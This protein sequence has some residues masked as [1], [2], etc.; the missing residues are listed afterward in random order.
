MREDREYYD[1]QLSKSG[2]ALKACM[3]SL[4][5]IILLLILTGTH[6]CLGPKG[7]QD[8][9]SVRVD[10]VRDTVYV[11]V[12][13]TLPQIKGERIIRY[14]SI[15]A[16]DSSENAAE[17]HEGKD[18]LPVVQRTFSDD[19]T[20]TAYVSGVLAG[21]WPRLDSISVRQREI[22]NTIRETVTV[23]KKA[24]QWKVGLQAGY[25]YGMSYKGFEPYVGVGVSYTLW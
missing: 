1:R 19:S 25:G 5:G 18:S 14:V 2:G 16:K 23:R 15:P 17:M 21:E 8:T 11:T 4:A 12:H 13:D 10:S 24:S 22:T 3:F 9:V 20:Y 6:Q 7:N